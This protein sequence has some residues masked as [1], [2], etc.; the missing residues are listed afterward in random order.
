[1]PRN[2]LIQL[3][4]LCARRNEVVTRAR[5]GFVG[6]MCYFLSIYYKL[7]LIFDIKTMPRLLPNE[8]NCSTQ[9]SPDSQ[10][11]ENTEANRAKTACFGDGNRYVGD[12]HTLHRRADYQRSYDYNSWHTMLTSA[13]ISDVMVD[14]RQFNVHSNS[15]KR[16][17]Q[18]WMSNQETSELMSEV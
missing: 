6:N 18:G 13:S 14:K 8:I 17:K 3:P 16:S 4:R 7:L 10:A 11:C 15:Y 1:M 9:L 12:L 2:H 5:R